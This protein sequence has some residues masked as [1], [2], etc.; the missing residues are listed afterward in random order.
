MTNSVK[1]SFA[2]SRE[3]DNAIQ[4]QVQQDRTNKSSFVSDV[5]EALLLSKLGEQLKTRAI[6]DKQTLLQELQDSL[7][8]TE[9]LSSQQLEQ[10]AEPTGRTT[11]EVLEEFL[12]LLF[13]TIPAEKLLELAKRSQR[14]PV[15]FLIHLISLGLQLYERHFY[16]FDKMI[17]EIQVE[18]DI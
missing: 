8:A 13:E 4:K 1:A 7:K 2:T 5:M 12:Q 15:Y 16:S 9:I 3:I 11:T 14:P 10:L 17:K 6:K 18:E